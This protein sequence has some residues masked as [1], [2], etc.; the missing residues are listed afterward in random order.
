VRRR[1]AIRAPRSPSQSRGQRR[2]QAIRQ[3]AGGIPPTPISRI[4]GRLQEPRIA[5]LLVPVL[6]CVLGAPS[7]WALSDRDRELLAA[8]RRGD[9][10]RVATLIRAGA[11]VNATTASGSTALIETVASG[12]P[13]VARLLLEAGANVDARHRELGT[14]LDAAERTGQRELATLLRAHGAR[15]SGKSLGDTVCVRRWSGSGFCAMVEDRRE[16]RFRLRVLRLEGCGAG[17]GP[18]EECS[19]GR[20]VGGTAEDALRAG[21]EVLVPSWCLT[22]TA[23]P[24]GQ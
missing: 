19:S 22:D 5:L 11:D 23:V 3:F 7:G 4:G 20:A 8:A 16:N 21:A 13:E 10:V 1:A 6:V 15:G 12:R 24:P 9:V 2:G 17:C 18:D 14:A